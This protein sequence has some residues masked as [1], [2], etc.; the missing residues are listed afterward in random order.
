MPAKL[1]RYRI[2]HKLGAGGMGTVYLAEDGAIRRR[3]ALKV[4]HFDAS[5]SPEVIKRFLREAQVAGAIEHPHICPIYDIGED[6]GSHYLVMPY[7]EGKPL[8]HW[9]H[10]DQPWPVLQAVALVRQLAL[11]IEVMHQKGIIHRDLK[12]ANVM[13]RTSGEPV[14]M[15]FGL[16]RSASQRMT[17]AGHPVGTPAYMSPE[18]VLGAQDDMGPATDV[19]SLG[20]ILYELV[21]GTVPF[22]GPLHAVWGQKLAGTPRPPSADR[23][24]L[25]NSLDALCLTAMAREVKERPASMAVFAAALTKYLQSQEMEPP[26]A[27]P[28]RPSSASLSSPITPTV[29]GR[30]A[31]TLSDQALGKP[32][33]RSWVVLASLLA[34]LLLAVL[35]VALWWGQ[36]KLN[37]VQLDGVTVQAGQTVAAEVQ[38]ERR[39]CDGPIE[40]RVEGLPE[41]VQPHPGLI[42]AGAN[43]GHLELT[44][45]K[46]AALGKKTVRLVAIAAN[47]R[48][49]GTFDLTVQPRPPD[50]PPLT[51]R[52]TLGKLPHITVAAGLTGA[53]PVQVQREHCPGVIKLRLE[54]LPDGVRSNEAQILDGAD[55]ATLELSADLDATP[56]T[57][58]VRLVADGAAARDQSDFRITTGKE[59]TNSIGM[60]LVRIPHGRFQMGS[61]K[62]EAGQYDKEMPQHEV[63]ISTSFYM[64]VYP[65]TVGQFRRFVNETEYKTAAETVGAGNTWRYVGWEQTDDHPVV[66]VTWHDAVKFCQWLRDKEKRTY[67]LPTEA[68]WEYACRAGTQTAYS[69]GDDPD[70]LTEY[71]WFSGNSWGKTHVVGQKKANPWGLFD[72]QGN[73]WQWCGDG[74]R[75]YEERK[76]KDPKGDFNG[77]HVLRGGSYDS[78]PRN[79]RAAGRDDYEPGGTSYTIGFRVVL[80]PAPRTP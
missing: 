53:L 44:A 2:L 32:R 62:G 8:A 33:R 52:L 48:T 42:P 80:R 34:G 31:L 22:H 29:G 46:A 9:I 35:F 23:P 3:V 45:D 58:T 79:C 43:R 56:V 12:P 77:R 28:T 25:D 59:F 51:A 60:K 64:G 17:S 36:P 38:I 41:G 67:A 65:V 49:Q 26:T 40:L 15:D 73:V 14:L 54:G 30:I 13:I 19:Y 24:G 69:F 7:I 61:P 72:M 78:A 5:D 55:A 57:R 63:E 16:A 18:Q 70:K 71:A 20:V 75:K 66:Y 1:G 6:N 4:P 76:S 39:D 68:E 74:P 47:A 37:L 21:T 27:L 10:P 50:A 11:G